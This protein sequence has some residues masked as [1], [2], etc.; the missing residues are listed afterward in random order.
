MMVGLVGLLPRA[1]LPLQLAL[2]VALAALGWALLGG[3]RFSRFDSAWVR[4]VMHAARF[5]RWTTAAVGAASLLI[6]A[7]ATT[8]AAWPLVAG[9]LLMAAARVHALAEGA[10]REVIELESSRPTTASIEAGNA[11]IDLNRPLKP[12]TA[13]TRRRRRTHLRSRVL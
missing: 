2:A 8:R 11:G 1:M 13:G 12:N 10:A 4:R 5:A 7:F 9:V 6:G 3:S